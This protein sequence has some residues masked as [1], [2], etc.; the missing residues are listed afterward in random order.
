MPSPLPPARVSGAVSLVLAL[1]TI[2]V[3]CDAATTP[4]P[5]TSASSAAACGPDEVAGGGIAAVVV[6]PDGNAL[7]DIFVIIEAADGFRGDARTGA[8]GIFSAPDV[9]GEFRITTVDADY[10]QLVRTVLVP[11]GELV[12][13]ELVL[14]PSGG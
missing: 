10:E 6:D 13:L 1:A 14:T 4:S 11:C 8:N 3:A 2:V 5:A 9:A 7:D 12:E